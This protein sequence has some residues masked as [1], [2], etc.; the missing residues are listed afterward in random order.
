MYKEEG[1]KNPTISGAIVIR[2]LIWP[3]SYV[4]FQNDR[5]Y[6]FYVGNG[7]KADRKEYYPILPPMVLS[8]PQE[9]KEQDEPNPKELPPGTQTIETLKDALQKVEATLS[10]PEKIE[11]V[12]TKA[13]DIIDTEHTGSIEKARLEEFIKAVPKVIEIQFDAENKAKEDFLAKLS[14]A[15]PSKEEGEHK[16]AVE[17]KDMGEAFKSFLETWAAGLK[18]KIEKPPQA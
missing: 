11:E 10:A 17:K 16:T 14:G 6:N 5:W 13:F 7:E 15:P 4:L 12:L 18:E 1:K 3:G 2:S 9:L 8:E